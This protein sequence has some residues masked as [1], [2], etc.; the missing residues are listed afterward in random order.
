M[1]KKKKDSSWWEHRPFPNNIVWDIA[2]GAAVALTLF[3]Y[4]EMA[5]HGK[6]TGF[7]RHTRT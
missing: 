3:A 1:G 6:D 5:K 2:E 7:D 4:Y